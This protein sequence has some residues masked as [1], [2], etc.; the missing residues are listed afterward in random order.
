MWC[1]RDRSRSNFSNALHSST[2]S[3]S[4]APLYTN[5]LGEAI[6]STA[7]SSRSFC[8]AVKVGESHFFN[9]LA[10]KPT[11]FSISHALQIAQ[12]QSKEQRLFEDSGPHKGQ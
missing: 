11:S 5:M 1:R 4:S 6:N 3:A 12:A 2:V 9:A 10:R 8:A 7:V